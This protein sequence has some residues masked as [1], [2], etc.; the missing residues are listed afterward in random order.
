MP[1]QIPASAQ[2]QL[3]VAQPR[4][5]TSS[6]LVATAQFDPPA[7]RPGEQT[8]YRV[9]INATES[10]IQWPAAFSLPGALGPARHARGQITETTVNSFRPLSSFVYELHPGTAGQFT[11]PGFTVNVGDSSVQV[12]SATLEVNAGLASAPPARMLA[13]ELSDTNLYLGQPFHVRVIL[14]SGPGNQ[15]EALREVALEGEGLMTDR[16]ATEESIGPAQVGDQLK[17]S[18]IEQLTVTPLA[19]GPLKFF[20]KGF[21]AGHEFTAPIAIRGAVSLVGG[22]PSYTLLLSEAQTLNVR[23]LP[24]DELP[25]FTGSIGR[26]FADPP[27]L[28]TNRLSVGEPLQL[29]YIVHGQGDLSR[30]APPAPPASEDWEIIQEPPPSTSFTLV[31]LTDNIRET[32]AIPFSYFDPELGRYEDL[33]I[34]ALPV[35][36]TGDKLPAEL[37]ASDASDTSAPRLK[38]G[39]LE[40]APGKSVQRLQP[41]QLRVWMPMVQVA[42]VLILLALWQWDRRR[43]YLEAHPEIVRRAKARRA[44]RREKIELQ[45]AFAAG[46][47]RGFVAHAARA[48]SI[49]VAPQLPAN[50]QAL[51]GADVIAHLD[52]GARSGAAGEAVKKVF[53]AADAQFAATPPTLPELAAVHTGVE[54]AL[55]QLEAKL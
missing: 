26:F 52:D 13:I 48:M 37:P 43:R 28:S 36:V 8:T 31:P 4:V 10:D 38:L 5:D 14:P 20:A 34:P 6:P 40:T 47:A 25:G 12:P 51:V 27:R 39:D 32:P 9:S 46:D 2:L 45:R 42:P 11:V 30:L 23:P 53:A 49:A 35:T 7:V 16:N 29:S 50:P 21:T 22:Q 54:A 55:Q 19:A 15:V 44:L 24:V 33:S 18:F 3:Q 1:P 17:V 41:A